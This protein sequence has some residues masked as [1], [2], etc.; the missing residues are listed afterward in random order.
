MGN[1]DVGFDIIGDIHGHAGELRALL[2][3]MGYTQHGR[4]YRHLGRKVLFVGDFVDRGPAIGEVIEIV[5]SMVDANDA[6]AVMGNHEYNAIAFHTSVPGKQ[7]S[8]F[9]PHSE[10]NLKQHE[11][12]LKQL[13]STQLNDALKWFRTLPVALDVDGIRVVHAAW[14]AEDIAN[15]HGALK[16][17]GRFTIEF[18]LMAEEDGS[19]LQRAIENVLKGPELTLPAGYF[20]LDKANHKRDTVRIKWYEDGVGKTYREHHLGN[21]EVPDVAIDAN[22]LNS[23]ETYASDAAPVFVGHYWLTGT[24]KPL[25]TNVACTDYSVAKGGKLVA[26]RWD[27]EPTLREDKFHW[28]GD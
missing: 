24:P 7:D 26:Y 20:I 6:L 2:A 17:K 5:R 1:S 25:T 22:D 12:T 16:T 21:D 27:G 15:I 28:V 11:E 4:G 23:F 3:G 8:W 10:K 18:L 13:S 14:Q 19:D 9:R